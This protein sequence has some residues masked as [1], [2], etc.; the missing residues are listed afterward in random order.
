MTLSI[1]L[2]MLVLGAAAALTTTG[3]TAGTVER[4]DGS[5]LTPA[6]LQEHAV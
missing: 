4:S 1:R 5:S 3:C 6:E 2:G